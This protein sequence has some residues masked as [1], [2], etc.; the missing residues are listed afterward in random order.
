MF[1]KFCATQTESKNAV[2]QECRISNN[3]DKGYD[4]RYVKI[5][6][7]VAVLI[8]AAQGIFIAVN[9]IEQQGNYDRAEI[10]VSA[11]KTQGSEQLTNQDQ[12]ILTPSPAET[13][14]ENTTEESPD[15]LV[16]YLSIDRYSL[17]T[18]DES[19]VAYLIG[20]QQALEWLSVGSL[21]RIWNLTNPADSWEFCHL[22]VLGTFMSLSGGQSTP[23]EYSDFIGGC[24]SVV[25]IWLLDQ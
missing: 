3:L 22:Q 17:P 16:P 25:D 20:E 7:I 11:T 5:A 10:S 18:S 23:Q 12:S 15:G 4:K 21:D 13:F 19:S 6:G 2:C 9:Q 24:T 1:C 14:S 8:I